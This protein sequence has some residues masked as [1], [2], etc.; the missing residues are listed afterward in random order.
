[1]EQAPIAAGP[2]EA[3]VSLEWTEQIAPNEECS[4][5]H[6]K[7]ETPFGR[8]LLTWKGWKDYPDYGFDETPWGGV[9]Y[10]GWGTVEEAQE[11]A[12]K[13]MWRRIS[14]CLQ[15]ERRIERHVPHARGTG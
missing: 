3:S 13:E 10:H 8:F 15:G 1:M 4:Y 6:T 5:N 7:A 9:E 12:A 14:A 11:W 2:L